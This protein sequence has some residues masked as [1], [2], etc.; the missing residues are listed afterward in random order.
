M[1]D[2]NKNKKFLNNK[3]KEIL[4]KIKNY[5]SAGVVVFSLYK[6]YSGYL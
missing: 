3:I 5:F 6:V 4:N 2:K 1:I